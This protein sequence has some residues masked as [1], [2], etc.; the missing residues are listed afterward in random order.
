[1]SS[2]RLTADGVAAEEAAAPEASVEDDR[3]V[4]TADGAAGEPPGTEGASASAAEPGAQA[5]GVA[6]GGPRDYLDD[7]RRVQADFEN[8]R[9]RMM[10]DQA[11]IAENA[12]ARIVEKLLPV[13][14]NFDL[15]IAHGEGGSGVELAAKE[16]VETLRSEGLEEIASEGAPFDPQVHD[17]VESRDDPSVQ[18]PTVIQVYRKGYRFKDRLLRAAMVV[19]A[20]PAQAEESAEA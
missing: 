5:T 9:K 17:A 1:M 8:Y 13:L 20:R 7:L 6:D 2:E 16:L 12:T 4:V 15:A 19:V 18:E 10:R 14:D 11:R 3:T